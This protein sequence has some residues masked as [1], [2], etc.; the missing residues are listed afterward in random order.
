[1]TLPQTVIK[2]S[3]V[4]QGVPEAACFDTFAELLGSL[5]QYLSVEIAASSISNVVI[6]NQQ[7][8]AL[9]KGKIWFR[10]DNSGSFLG[11]YVF[12]GTVWAQVLP[13][14]GQI[15]WINGNAATPPKG[16]QL[17]PDDTSVF[18]NVQYAALFPDTTKVYPAFFVGF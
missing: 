14:P 18:S 6:S 3:I 9:D 1:M 13:A 7:P 10:L 2:G 16:F 11:I 4:V 8:G 15:F 12:T 17:I 5:S